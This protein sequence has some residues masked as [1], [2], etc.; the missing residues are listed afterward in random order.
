MEFNKFII[1]K[2]HPLS[3]QLVNET[4]IYS[5]DPTM[6]ICILPF[7]KQIK[8]CAEELCGGEKGRKRVKHSTRPFF[9]ILLFSLLIQK[10]HECLYIYIHILRIRIL[11]HSKN[12]LEEKE[13]KVIHHSSPMDY[14]TGFL[15]YAHHFSLPPS[16]SFYFFISWEVKVDLFHSMTSTSSV[17]CRRS[18]V[19]WWCH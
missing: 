6:Y 10:I 18:A 14:V 15:F 5:N 17:Q 12:G 8:K 16:S 7:T 9:I 13:S 2:L 11:Y 4:P 19:Q 3:L 1:K